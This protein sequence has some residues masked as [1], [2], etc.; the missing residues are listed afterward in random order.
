MAIPNMSVE[1]LRGALKELE[2]AAYNHDQWA[3]AITNTLICHLT[4][5]ER[6]TRADAH[7][8]CRFG[9]W[10]YNTG[11]A[12]LKN[13]PGFAEIG[14]EH[15]HVHQA[16]ANLLRLS[17]DSVPISIADLDRFAN[18]RKRLILE[19]AT[20]RREFEVALFN[21][22]PLTGIPSRIAMLGILREQQEFARRGRACAVTMM[23]IDH[24]KSVN[25]KYGH[26]VG[27]KVLIGFAACIMAHIRP[28][29]RLFRYGGEEFLICLPDTDLQAARVIV[30]RLREELAT[31][32][33]EARDKEHFQAA[34]SFGLTLL[35]P[36]IPVEQSIDRA[37]KA[38]YVAKE[39]GRN[40]V[41]N[42]DASMN[43]LPGWIRV[44]DHSIEYRD[45][46]G[47]LAI[48]AC[49]T[50]PRNYKPKIP[51]S[52][53]YSEPAAVITT[54]ARGPMVRIRS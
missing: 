21:L 24:F 33:F 15:E 26:L 40:R 34:A 4:P 14:R 30:D 48:S 54:P 39:T 5:D 1:Q 47:E 35:E 43:G 9:Q 45:V 6:D 44:R 17:V 28:Y 25:D 20:V 27:D 29:D 32:P 2:Q 46:H 16:A 49:G 10:F 42:W 38:L 37:D 23:D 13:Y 52:P 31:L 19:I 22:D 51:L 53:A 12:A 3:E 18:A 36:N 50:R 41:V 11:I 8:E 7:R